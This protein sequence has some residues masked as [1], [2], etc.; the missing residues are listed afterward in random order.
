VNGWT[1]AKYALAVAGLVLVVGAD[2]VGMR[3]LS[4]PGLGLILVAFLLRYPQRRALRR[5][6]RPA[7]TTQT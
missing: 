7:D 5:G 3:W 1:V 4:Y 2:R 6:A